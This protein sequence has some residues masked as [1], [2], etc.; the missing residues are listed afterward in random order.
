MTEP[1]ESETLS[2][3]LGGENIAEIFEGF[4]LPTFVDLMLRESKRAD[5]VEM[6]CLLFSHLLTHQDVR[7]HIT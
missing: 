4:F 6:F 3:R 7:L 1:I 5:A 2:E